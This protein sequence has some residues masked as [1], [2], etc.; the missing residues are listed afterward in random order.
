[1]AFVGDLLLSRGH[2]EQ[3]RNSGSRV[4]INLDVD[5]FAVELVSQG[6]A[7]GDTPLEV[8]HVQTE[9]PHQFA[10]V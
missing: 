9:V 4:S 7:L 3:L 8:A 1:V 6:G 2:L 5:L 10:N